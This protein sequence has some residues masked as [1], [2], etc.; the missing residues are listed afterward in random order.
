MLVRD[1]HEGHDLVED[2]VA[3]H[4]YIVCQICS[5]FSYSVIDVL[6]PLQVLSGDGFPEDESVDRVVIAFLH[7]VDSEFDDKVVI[8]AYQ[9]VAMFAELVH[10][11]VCL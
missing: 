8:V 5:V 10:Y 2:I 7:V 9:V 3:G 11:L 1:E 6:T 4:G